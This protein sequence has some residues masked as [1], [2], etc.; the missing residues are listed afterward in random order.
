[1]IDK[2]LIVDDEFMVREI[3]EETTRRIGLSVSSACSGKEAVEILKKEVFQVAFVDLKMKKINGYDVLKYCSENCPGMLVIIM[4]AYG[5]IE[6]AVK[7][8]KAG[9]FDF[10]LK[11]FTP[12]QVEIALDKG[13]SWMKL[14]ARQNYFQRELFG[15]Y[16]HKE[17]FYSAIGNSKKMNDVRTLL[18]R[19]APTSST[20]LICGKSGTGKELISS[21]I[22]LIS[23]PSR[24]KPYIRLNCASVPESL[25]ESELFGHEKGSFTGAVERRIGRFELADGG[26]LL[27]D[28]VSEITVEMQAKL[29]RAIQESEFER[30]GGNKTIKVNTR[31]IAT[32]NRDLKKEVQNGNFREDLYYRLNVFPIELPPLRDRGEDIVTLANYFLSRQSSKLR[33]ELYFS[34][35]ALE[36]LKNYNWPGN[37]RELENIVERVSILEDGPV[38]E[39]EM[40]PLDILCFCFDGQ[41][42]DCSKIGS[43]IFDLKKI[44]KFTIQSALK[45]M[46]GNQ[47]RAAKLLGFSRRTLINKMNLY[48]DILNS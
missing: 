35:S 14:N 11:P 36:E 22:E 23:N 28:E 21:E 26:T 44:E 27:L 20:V 15:E 2:V 3:M 32:T 25:L 29:L 48:D 33:K 45:K 30:V 47:T 8:M 19:V 5:A 17:F 42:I 43:D 6:D 24:I 7:C 38:I 9:A 16:K 13:K 18:R 46:D 12:D 10:V 1:M 40:L 34:D 37:V 31:I 4:T 39:K 41:L